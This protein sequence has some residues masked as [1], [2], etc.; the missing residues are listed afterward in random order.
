LIKMETVLIN[1]CALSNIVV[2]SCEI[3]THLTYK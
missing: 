3:F 2:N 1:N